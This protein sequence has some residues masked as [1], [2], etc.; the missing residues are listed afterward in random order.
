MGE[1]FVEAL[2][3]LIVALTDRVHRMRRKFK[4]AIEDKCTALEEDVSPV[5]TIVFDY[6]MSFGFDPKVKRDE[7]DPTQPS[8]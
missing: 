3:C 4:D 7:G 6:V 8:A 2:L 1:A 5:P